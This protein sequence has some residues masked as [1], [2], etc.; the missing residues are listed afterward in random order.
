MGA[1]F[2]K[3]AREK[4]IDESSVRSIFARRDKIKNQGIQAADYNVKIPIRVL[5][6]THSIGNCAC[7]DKNGIGDFLEQVF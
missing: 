6:C 1:G 7:N 2:T 3:I 5:H 4:G